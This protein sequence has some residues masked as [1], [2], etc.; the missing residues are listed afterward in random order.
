MNATKTFKPFLTSHLL[1]DEI[2]LSATDT[3]EIETRWFTLDV[4]ILDGNDIL[5]L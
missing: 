2:H 4:S 1:Y 5:A 3:E